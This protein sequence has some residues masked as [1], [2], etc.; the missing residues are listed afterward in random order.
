MADGYDKLSALLALGLQAYIPTSVPLHHLAETSNIMYSHGCS[1]RSGNM[2]ASWRHIQ[3]C[4]GALGNHI[5]LV[6]GKL[7]PELI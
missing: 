2:G 1:F 3:Q 5:C 4:T 7:D 6:D